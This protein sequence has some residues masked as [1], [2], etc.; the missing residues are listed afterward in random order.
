MQ[1]YCNAKV[2]Q[3]LNLILHQ[4]L[5]HN[6]LDH[7]IHPLDQLIFTTTLQINNLKELE[8]L[9]LLQDLEHF[10]IFLLL[11]YLQATHTAQQQPLHLTLLPVVLEDLEPLL[12]LNGK[13][14]TRKLYC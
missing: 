2:S 1:K 10:L 5:L 13:E 3:C 7:N 14:N 4:L 12:P 6:D 8:T 9:P 11:L